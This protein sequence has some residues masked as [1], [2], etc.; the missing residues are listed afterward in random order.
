MFGAT[1]DDG[2][3]N[4]NEDNKDLITMNLDIIAHG[5]A[6]DKDDSVANKEESSVQKDGA[7]EVYGHGMTIGYWVGI[8]AVGVIVLLL[9]IRRVYLY[10]SI[11][12]DDEYSCSSSNGG[13]YTPVGP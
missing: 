2:N 4:E 6:I 11:N 13:K 7:A 12:D 9:M 5:K 1:D 8:G 3:V 10:C